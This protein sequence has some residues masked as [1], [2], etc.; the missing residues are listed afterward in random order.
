MSDSGSRSPSRSPP[1]RRRSRSDSRDARREEVQRDEMRPRAEIDER[2]DRRDRNGKS[3][4]EGKKSRS[5]SPSEEDRRGGKTR[6]RRSRSR[7]ESA[8]PERRGR[9]KR[10]RR[11]RSSSR[12]ASSDSSSSR[13]RRSSRDRR[14]DKHRKK[15]AAKEK[16]QEMMKQQVEQL[17]MLSAGGRAGGVYIPPHKLRMLQAQ[18]QQQ[19]RASEQYQRLTWEAL[20]KSLN[21]LINKVS[22]GNITNIVFDLFKENIIR[23][24]GLLCRSVM[25]SQQA[26]MAF[27][28]VYAALIAI[29]NTKMPEIGELLL[30]RL[31]DLFKKSWRRS[32]KAG[33]LSSVRF[34]A[35]LFN[36]QVCGIILPLEILALLLEHP[37]DD[38]VEIGV[39]FMLEVGQAL[40]QRS[41]QGFN[42]VFE[43]F[44]AILHEGEIDKRVQYMIENLFAVRKGNFAN[45]PSVPSN[46]DLVEEEDQIP[47]ESISLDDDMDIEEHLNIFQLDP[48]FAENEAK[49]EEIKRS[50]IG[51][52]DEQGGEE[53]DGEQ[54]DGELDEDNQAGTVVSSASAAN[55]SAIEDMTQT[56]LVNLKRSIYL[57]IMSSLDFEEVG[58]K[59]MKMQLRE[60]QEQ[61]MARMLLECCTQERTFIRTYALV[62]QRFSMLKKVYQDLFGELFVES[63]QTIHRYDTNKLRNIANF[64]SHM[65]YTDALPWTLFEVIKLNERD[66][67]SSSRIFIKILFQDLAQS[68]GYPKL[69]ARLKDPDMQEFYEGIFPRDNPRDTR[70]AINFFTA[71]GLGVLTEDMRVWLAEA[72]KRAA[73]KAALAPLEESSSSSSSS[74]SLSSSSDSSDSSDSDSDSSSSSS[75]SDSESEP[76]KKRSRRH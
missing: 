34:I 54:G 13:S 1:R 70:F 18:A 44:R 40:Q 38:S 27:T 68:F 53:G 26:S 4:T 10:K 43:R 20:R 16:E 17:G 33:L 39:S 60:G 52:D 55:N 66:T 31:V 5:R 50:I 76:P 3:G 8:S 2:E 9:N 56:D 64:F 28:S 63:F 51:D 69:A 23:G 71:I 59:L 61:H 21:G 35:H 73:E 30:K 14:R 58:H 6:S 19:D 75:S 62:A 45:H 32:N 41:P 49:Y 25:K 24:R 29:I 12:S 72:A 22:T 65:F 47:H 15:D 67:T 74:S 36:Q 48:D 7:S 57:T 42:D 11:S 46:L 37:T